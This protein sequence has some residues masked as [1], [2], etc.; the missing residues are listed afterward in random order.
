MLNATQPSFQ[1]GLIDFSFSLLNLQFF[2]LSFTVAKL[3]QH[4]H[5][6]FLQL[7]DKQHHVSKEHVRVLSLFAKGSP[8]YL[9][10]QSK[11]GRNNQ[12]QLVK[13]AE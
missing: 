2:V 8:K 11:F 6:I 9:P 12:Q 10:F 5:F 1:Y 4:F 7:C 13:Y 3:I